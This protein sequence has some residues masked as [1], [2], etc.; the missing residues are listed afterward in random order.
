M[1]IRNNVYRWVGVA[2]T[3]ATVGG[4]VAGCGSGGSA[5]QAG[6]GSHAGS[7]SNQ[8]SAS[9]SV[10][11]GDA[12]QGIKLF[13]QNCA[14]CHSTGTKRVVGPGLKGLY[15]KKKLPNGEPVNDTN[16]ANWIRTGGGG[17]PGFPQLSDQ[18]RADIVAYLK[19]LG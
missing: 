6:G 10:A 15:S 4:F 13:Q 14:V 17:M 1:N 2:V 19:T 9:G 5:N 16:V 7:A 8:S 3:V 18:Q 11:T 12:N